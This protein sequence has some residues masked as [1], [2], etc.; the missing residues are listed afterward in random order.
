VEVDDVL[1]VK[2]MLDA[3]DGLSARDKSAFFYDTAKSVFVPGG[4][5]KARA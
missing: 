5:G 1:Y 2:R 4:R 3:A